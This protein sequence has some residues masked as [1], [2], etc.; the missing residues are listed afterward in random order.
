M[1]IDLLK[2]YPILLA[3]NSPRRKELLAEMGLSFTVASMDIDESF[4]LGISPAEAA[5]WIAS[6]KAKAALSEN[7]QSLIVAADTIVVCD[8]QVLGKPVDESHATKI[9]ELLSGQTHQVITA[10]ALAYKEEFHVFHEVTQVTFKKL[11]EGE[12][13]FYVRNYKPYDKAGAYGIQEWIGAIGI[14]RIDGSYTNVVGL[15]TARLYQ[16]L[17]D[18]VALS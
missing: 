10:V 18:F 16:E 13:S 7:Q 12:I 3:S 11:S 4:P 6:N 14:E 8:G 17:G 1:L 5:E 2:Q 15:P 9:L